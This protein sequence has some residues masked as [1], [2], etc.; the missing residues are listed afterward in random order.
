M[1]Y[2]LIYSQT[3]IFVVSC[4]SWFP[5]NV[6]NVVM[7]DSGAVPLSTVGDAELSSKREYRELCEKFAQVVGCRPSIVV[8]APGR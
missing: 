1:L 7:S 5:F 3:G 2:R 8:H 6:Q 4:D